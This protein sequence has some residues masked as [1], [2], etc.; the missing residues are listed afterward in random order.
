MDR[1]FLTVLGVS[2]LFA[3]VVSGVFYQMTNKSAP[4][5]RKTESVETKDLVVAAKP[6]E[7]GI[8]VKPEHV[9]VVKVPTA[10]FPR[11]GFSKVEEVLDRPV[12]SR[13]L[14]EEPIIDGRLAARGSGAGLAPIIP[15]GMRAVSVRI[16]DVVG[17]SGFAQ[18]GMRVDVLVTG[19]PS[20]ANDYV[21]KTVLQNILVLSTGSTMTANQKGEPID[22]PTVTLL[23]SLKDA[24]TLTLAQTEGKIQLVLRNTSDQNTEATGGVDLSSLYGGRRGRYTNTSSNPDGLEG[25]PEQRPRRRAAAPAPPTVVVAP[26]APAVPDQIVVIRGNTRSVETVSPIRGSAG[27]AQPLATSAPSTPDM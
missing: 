24:E 5:V 3:L 18:P 25:E 14:H 23:V 17:V 15:P 6:L 8:M 10:S 21:T 13:I 1:R 4:V 16:N 22:S 19:R 26:P 20:G 9:Q 11:G 2:L 27:T 7:V 12:I